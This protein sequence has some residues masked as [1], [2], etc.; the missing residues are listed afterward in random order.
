MA[1]NSPEWQIGLTYLDCRIRLT[2]PIPR[3]CF[4]LPSG[5]KRRKRCDRNSLPPLLP[6]ITLYYRLLQPTTNTLAVLAILFTEQLIQHSLF[7]DNLKAGD[8]P[9]KKYHTDKSQW[10]TQPNAE[11]SQ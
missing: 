5:L 6:V 3:P 1:I 9:H 2:L 4:L 7:R 8:V 11:A 10:R